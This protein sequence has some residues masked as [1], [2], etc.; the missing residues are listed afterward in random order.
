MCWCF[1]IYGC[2]TWVRSPFFETRCLPFLDI[3]VI[4][5]VGNIKPSLSLGFCGQFAYYKYVD[6]TLSVVTAENFLMDLII[7]NCSLSNS[8]L[9]T[10][11]HKLCSVLYELWI[12]SFS[13]GFWSQPIARQVTVSSGQRSIGLGSLLCK[14]TAIILMC[15]TR[16]AR[17]CCPAPQL[18][19]S[20]KLK[21]DSHQ[22]SLIFVD[23]EK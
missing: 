16:I 7:I 17:N 3:P 6:K 12:I 8:Y 2:L 11:Y 22:R 4:S 1:I 19:Y 9:D 5:T 15:E 18:Q 10:N 21:R 14:C 20:A 23:T 13:T